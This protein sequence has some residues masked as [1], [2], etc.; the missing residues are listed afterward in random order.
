[1]PDHDPDPNQNPKPDPDPDPTPDLDPDPKPDP[2]ESPEKLLNAVKATRTERDEAKRAAKAAEKERDALAARL[3][4]IEDAERSDLEKA[5]AKIADFEAR[6]KQ[7]ADERRLF[8]LRAAVQEWSEKLGIAS[9]SLALKALDRDE[10]EYGEDGEPK[11]LGDVLA[12]LL[13]RE[14]VL[15]GQA[16]KPKPG[17]INAGAGSG[18]E[19]PPAL[20][21]EELE[22]A[23]TTGMTPERYA[24]MKNVKSYDEWQALR[25]AEKA[26]AA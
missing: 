25:E 16:P 7:W 12:A 9:P 10:I 21:A 4:E 3:K 17:Q 11:N 18:G 14:P 19:K 23:T 20:T 26:S 22:A 5:E 15:K 8:T 6:E 1:M 13:E 24:A 2:E